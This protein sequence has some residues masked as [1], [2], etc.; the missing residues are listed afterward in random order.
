MGYEISGEHADT[1]IDMIG[2]MAR[3]LSG[4]G[5]AGFLAWIDQEYPAADCVNC[6]ERHGPNATAIRIN[7]KQLAAKFCTGMP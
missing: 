1:T 3:Y 7:L 4:P 2:H 5:F 6:G